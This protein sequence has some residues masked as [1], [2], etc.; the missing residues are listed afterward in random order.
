MSSAGT[1]VIP[2]QAVQVQRS[3][4]FHALLWGAYGLVAFAFIVLAFAAH[5][6]AYFPLDLQ[7]A[8]AIQ[9]IPV[10][11]FH[12]MMMAVSW[13]GFPPQAPVFVGV[14][15]LGYVLA[16]RRREGLFIAGSAIG[17]A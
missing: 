1:K 12:A 3:H 8:R 14:V 11:W 13:P 15:V 2:F 16:H 17:S 5:T 4:R 10:P 9:A 6:V 7:A